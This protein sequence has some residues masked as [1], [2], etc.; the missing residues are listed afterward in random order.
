MKSGDHCVSRWCPDLGGHT[1]SALMLV[2]VCV[3]GCVSQ[4][5]TPQLFSVSTK[6][7][8]CSGTDGTHCL[9][10][11]LFC[12]LKLFSVDS[13]DRHTHIHILC[14]S[15]IYSATWR[16]TCA[17][18]CWRTHIRAAQS[19]FKSLVLLPGVLEASFCMIS[20]SGDDLSY[21]TGLLSLCFKSAFLTVQ[22]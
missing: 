1:T 9:N 22:I 6:E 15:H 3:C 11:H 2:C 12:D 21:E 4:N 10:T 19:W 18:L 5:R 16:L 13:S 20:I 7:P 17:A 14:K 8:L